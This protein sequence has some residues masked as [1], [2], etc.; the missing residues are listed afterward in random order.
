MTD[1]TSYV[2]RSIGSNRGVP[3]IWLEGRV[4]ATAGFE[5]H[6]R[7]RVLVE[8]EKT[9]LVLKLD[10]EG[11]RKVSQK[12]KNDKSI[13]VID[14]NSAEVLDMFEGLK[15][16]RVWAIKGGICIAPSATEARIKTRLERIRQ[17]IDA[18]LP[19]SV[20]SVSHGGG[21]LSKAIHDGLN[22]GNVSSK[23]VFANDIREELLEHAS[24]H[25]PSWDEQTIM[26]SAP[27]QE[28]AFDHQFMA[29]LPQVDLLE[30]GI[31]CNG[32]SVAGRAK[33]GTECAEAHEDV[34]HLVVAFLAIVARVNPAIVV[35]ENVPPYASSSSMWII[36]HQLRDLGYVVHETMMDSR[37][38]NTIESRKRMCMTAVTRGMEFSMDAIERPSPQAVKLG[39]VM[40]QIPEDDPRWSE[41]G[42]LKAKQERDIAD[43][44]GFKMQIVNAESGQVGTIGKGYS[45]NR[46]T[47]PKV[48]HPTNPDLLRLLTVGE[49]AAVKGIDPKLISGL[50]NTTA[51]EVLGQSIAPQ[52]FISLAKAI[53][54][55]VLA[56]AGHIVV[57]A[58][59]E[60]KETAKA[61]IS[62]V[63]GV[64]P[65]HEETAPAVAMQVAASAAPVSQFALF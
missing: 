34:G 62:M 63:H 21:I 35:L 64:M 61:A 13:P 18:G 5:P 11:N 29:C 9:R 59:V 4:A 8:R 26:L 46:S 22:L 42:Y 7:F 19:L 10:D 41:M 50:C 47:E 43:G 27:M 23:L 52:P 49:H 31:P 40:E 53:A 30:G 15:E 48:S 60:V 6:K 33:A 24:E 20:G 12:F 45:K 55:T 56:Y 39:D 44:K 65:D 37:D 28:L 32:A 57:N 58:F 16:V 2:I 3:R 54:T 51:H 25:N 17:K 1:P 14:I 36:R 38:W